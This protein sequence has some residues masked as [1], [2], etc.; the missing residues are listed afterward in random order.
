M[1]ADGPIGIFGGTFDPVHFGHLRPALEALEE[2]GLAELRLIPVHVPAH[3]AMPAAGGDH[4]LELLRL[5]TAGIAGFRVDTRELDRP[6]PSYMVD[7]LIS[8]RREFPQRSL[9]LIL[10]MD[11]F[12]ALPHWHR[13][14]ELSELAHLVVLERPGSEP[15]RQGELAQWLAPRQVDAP[16]ALNARPAGAVYFL[17][18]TQLSI[19]ATRIRELIAAGRPPHFLLPEPV[20]QAIA[21]AG[22]YGW[23][24]GA[25]SDD[26]G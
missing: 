26:H 12:L 22:L 5:A 18:V 9:C 23:Q 11:S 3:R 25:G 15:P 24:G 7:T 6:G 1:R 21:A 17:P 14:R 10:G 13:W 8:L 19:S 20:W 16:A 4:R 2:L